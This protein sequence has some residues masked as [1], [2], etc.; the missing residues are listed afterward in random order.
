MVLISCLL[1]VDSGLAGIRLLLALR[2]AIGPRNHTYT[3]PRTH[4]HTQSTTTHTGWTVRM[5]YT[6]VILFIQLQIHRT[7][8]GHTEEGSMYVCMYTH[9]QSTVSWIYATKC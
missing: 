6:D 1:V 3:I 9:V 2:L 4:T 8:G 7:A 5:Y